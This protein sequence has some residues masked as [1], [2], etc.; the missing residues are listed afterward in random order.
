MVQSKPDQPDQWLWPCKEEL[1]P[2]DYSAKCGTLN[3]YDADFKRNHFPIVELANEK[4]LEAEQAVLD[5][6]TNRVREFLD[7]LFQLL[8]ELEKVSKKSPA[9]TVAEAVALRHL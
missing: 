6:H 5:N 9:T 4:D 7:H 1:A 8:S 3:E 2:C